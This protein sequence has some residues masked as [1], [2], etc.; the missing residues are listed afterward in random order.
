[1]HYFYLMIFIV[2]HVCIRWISEILFQFN[3]LYGPC[4]P[5]NEVHRD[6]KPKNCGQ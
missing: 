2:L 6:L 3:C 1:M 5:K 4:S